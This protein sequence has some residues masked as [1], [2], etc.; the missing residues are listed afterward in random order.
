MTAVSAVPALLD[1]LVALFT[2]ALPTV[3]VFD[4]PGL[5][6]ATGGDYLFVGV[7]DPD[8]DGGDNAV[9]STVEWAGLG[10][11]ARYEQVVVRCAAVS[12]SGD[13]DVRARR[14]AAF[15]MFAAVEQAL[16][17]D[18]SVG[19]VARFG[20]LATEHQLRQNITENGAEAWV[21]F[22]LSFTA[23]LSG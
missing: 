18:P 17:S 23:R 7:A 19:D 12:W 16:T 22:A 5:S 1:A 13:E 4:G 11:S 8:S 2:A 15:A 9:E 6:D 20:G 3:T 21:Q 14:V 10:K